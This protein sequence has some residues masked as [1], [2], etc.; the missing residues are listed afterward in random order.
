VWVSQFRWCPCQ[1]LFALVFQIKARIEDRRYN[2]VSTLEKGVPLEGAAEPVA[3]AAVSG[4][5][6]QRPGKEARKQMLA[7]SMQITWEGL[8]SRL[9]KYVRLH[10]KVK[11]LSLRSAIT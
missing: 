10:F 5:Q 9:V 4:G 8:T 11:T 2:M 1:T 3:R 7:A 6:Q